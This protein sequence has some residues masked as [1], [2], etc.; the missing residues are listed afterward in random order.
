MLVRLQYLEQEAEMTNIASGRA[1]FLQ[2][3]I[4]DAYNRLGAFDQRK[5]Y[6]FK[7]ALED[8]TISFL[9]S[10][11]PY[12]KTF[13]GMNVITHPN[14]TPG[15]IIIAPS[16]IMKLTKEQISEMSF[17]IIEGDEEH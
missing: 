11:G 3:C 16:D 9:V 6:I 10:R 12:P 13:M 14:M 2:K 1:E 7:K 15:T 17:K 5:D 4:I 8:K